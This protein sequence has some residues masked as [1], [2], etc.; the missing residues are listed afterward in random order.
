MQSQKQCV[1]FLHNITGY[2]HSNYSIFLSVL[3]LKVLEVLGPWLSKSHF[4]LLCYFP[5]CSR[6]PFMFTDF[7]FLIALMVYYDLF[8]TTNRTTFF[9]TQVFSLRF[10]MSSKD[11]LAYFFSIT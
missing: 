8:T 7:T 2:S 10:H 9:S 5:F 3:V 11:I 6:L 4:T 1:L